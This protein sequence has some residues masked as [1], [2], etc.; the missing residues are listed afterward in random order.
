MSSVVTLL[1]TDLADSPDLRNGDERLRR[2][3]FRLVSDAVADGHGVKIVG[4]GL[5]VAFTS[6]LQ[7][8]DAA[9]ATQRAIA[10]HNHVPGNRPFSARIGLHAGEPIRHEDDY[11]GTAVVLAKRLCDAAEGGQI[12]VSDPVRSVVMSRGDFEFEPVGPLKLKGLAEP[13]D[14]YEL[15]WM[16]A[17]GTASAAPLAPDP[18]GLRLVGRHRHLDVLDEEV[19]IA[20]DGRLRV[21]LL[22]GEPGVGKTRLTTELL[23]R[24][25][26]D[27]IGL[28]AR[29]YP[30]GTTD[31][32]GLW[33]EALEGHLRTLD[34]TEINAL[35][36][37]HLDDLAALLPSVAAA[38]GRP[39]AEPPRVRLLGGLAILLANLN[40]RAPLVVVLDDVHLADGSSWEALNYLARNL[41]TSSITVVLVARPIELAEHAMASDVILALEQ[42][43]LLRRDVLTPLGRDEVGEL[44]AVVLDQAVTEPLVDW[45]M[46]RSRGSPL[47][48]V[49]LLRALVD[50]GADLAN[51]VLQSLPEDLAE[52]VEARLR[53]LD[54]SERSMLELIAVVGARVELDE[55]LALC[56]RPLDEVAGS[57]E[58]L[59]RRRLLVEEDLGRTLRYEVGHPLIQEAIYGS[60]GGARRHSLHRFV[61]RALVASNRFG[62]AAG[63]F[64]QSASPGD[65]EAITAVREALRQAEARELHRESLALLKALLEI[66]PAGDRRWLDVF[67]AMQWQA[68][69]I[70]DHRA[71]VGWDT[72]LSAM[73]RIDQLLP[74]SGDAARRGTAKFHLGSFLIWGEGDIAGGGALIEE[75]R[76]LYSAAGRAESALLAVS[77]TSYVRGIGGDGHAH[78]E[79]ARRVI[80][81]ASE[82]GWRLAM[83]QGYCSLAHALLW[84]GQ[85]AELPDVI[86]RG[87]QLA[88][89]DGRLYRVAYLLGQQGVASA[90]HGRMDDARELLVGARASNPGFRDTLLFDWV[91]FIEWLSGGMAGGVAA[92]REIIAWDGGLVSRRHALGACVSGLCALEIGELDEAANTSEAATRT[93]GGREW[94]LHSAMADWLRAMVER[95]RG[96]IDSAVARL[97]R[98]IAYLGRIHS[99][100][101]ATFTLVAL[102]ELSA[103]L[104]EPDPLRRALEAAPPVPLPPST[105]ALNA[106]A[107]VAHGA[108]AMA[109]SR[110]A[111]AV[112]P[113]ESAVAVLDAGCWPFHAARARVLLGRAVANTDRDRAVRLLA[114]AAGAFADSGAVEREAGAVVLL[115]SLGSKGRRARTA[116]SGPAALTKREREVATLASEG[117]SNHVIAARLFIGER[118]V[119]THLANAYAKLGVTSRMELARHLNSRQ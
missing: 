18:R 63:H 108:L 35:C 9:I 101:M 4:D 113:L 66:V 53:Q 28:T 60:I 109:E 1:Y 99:G 46:E 103:E 3:H 68:E 106:L 47:Y 34:A 49:G 13:V 100:L 105:P 12:L 110:P 37:S 81:E 19:E 87:L 95:A 8:L 79:M 77:E 41:A 57:L 86:D 94:W 72:G 64:V 26:E 93:F 78:E 75:A 39:A 119:E 25:T 48:A 15:H 71:D 90:L 65:D 44:A 61:A 80:A 40:K 88:R 117:L 83:L 33:V 56:G 50:E 14:A 16:P 69:W 7:A 73:R 20:G 76:E 118:T 92:G 107:D 22:T 11:F 70:V 102:A 114:D 52:R 24:H 45:L 42:E 10:R 17:S 55:L 27:A 54:A 30:L 59:V 32:L 2:A 67:D 51:P 6:P 23:R 97:E 104:A 89:E 116:V 38:G 43:G 21:V 115:D 62:S 29:A 58:Q 82:N 98:T 112:A 31:S 36:G 85:V 96:D 5:I 74:S 91:A 84:S 111:D